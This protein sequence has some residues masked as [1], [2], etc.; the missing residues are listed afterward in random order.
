MNVACP[1]LGA[2]SR[3]TAGGASRCKACHAFVVLR[4]LF[5]ILHEALSTYGG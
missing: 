3:V 1:L 5:C 4:D 2:S